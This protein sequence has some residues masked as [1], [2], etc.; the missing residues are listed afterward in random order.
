MVYETACSAGKR[1][2]LT[3]PPGCGKTTVVRKVADLLRG[4]ASGFYTE[5]IRD[6]IGQ[7]IGFQVISLE[8][9]RG[10]LARKGPGSGPRVGSYLVN[11]KDFERI[12]LPSLAAEAGRVLL[13]DEIGKMECCSEEF[14]R[15]VGEVFNSEISIL[16]TIP[17]RGGGDFIESVRRRRDAE[18]VLVT[19]ENR[20]AL[21]EQLVAKLSPHAKG[22][23]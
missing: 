10:E 18:T 9:K 3:G 8:G 12:A 13:I 22:K 23:A 20:E 17:L 4:G 6:D 19:R 16:A 15:R 7:R 2:L 11:V 1:I 14:V 21:P 5:E